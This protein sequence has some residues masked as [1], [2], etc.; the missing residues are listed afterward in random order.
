MATASVKI[1][2]LGLGAPRCAAAGA[3]LVLRG[4]GRFRP[5]RA[6]RWG[7]GACRGDDPRAPRGGRLAVLPR[8]LPRP[9]RPLR[10]GARVGARARRAPAGYRDGRAGV[11]LHELGREGGLLPRPGR[12]HRRADRA[13]RSRRGGRHRCRS[14]LPS[15]SGSPRSGSSATLH[16]SPP[17]WS[18]S[19]GSEVW[20][21]TVEGE[22]R[23]AFV[24]AKARTLILCRAG[25]PWLPTG[26]PAEAHPVEVTLV[27]SSEGLVP[28]DDGGR[29]SMTAS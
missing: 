13:P 1:G 2:H 25:R 4:P 16:P 24:G 19:S 12:E 27:G 5:C 18:T 17:R 20:D 29:V 10:R 14:R 9:G 15:C 8:R 7:D 3:R 6:G 22:G 23:L 28:L 26:R 21:G 11:R